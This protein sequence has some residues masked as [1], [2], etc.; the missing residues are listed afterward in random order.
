MASMKLKG[1]TAVLLIA[2]GYYEHEYWYPYYRFLEEGAE[3]ITAGIT[4]GIV[5]GEGIHGTD[6][7]KAEVKVAVSDLKTDAFDILFLPG[8]IYG[9]MELRDNDGVLDLVRKCFK[10]NKL[11]CTICHSPWI[12]VSAGVL[13]G[14]KI[15]CPRD[16]SADVIGAGAEFIFQPVVV[17][18]NL[19]SAEA[20]FSM[21]EMFRALFDI[22]F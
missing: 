6:G 16:I 22:Y 10:E 8:G 3:V 12:L 14:R 7:L 20:Y 21:P 5:R 19:L 2:E 15:T 9:P 11:V 4:P 17:D 18:G 1:K 13:K